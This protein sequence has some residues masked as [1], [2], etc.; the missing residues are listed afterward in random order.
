MNDLLLMLIVMQD[1]DKFLLLCNNNKVVLIDKRNQF[2]ER[3]GL[4]IVFTSKEDR[5]RKFGNH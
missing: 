1:E 4:K 3:R 5:D 2:T